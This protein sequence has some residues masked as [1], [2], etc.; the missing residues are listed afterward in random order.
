MGEQD[1]QAPAVVVTEKEV[2]DAKV[3]LA[4]RDYCVDALIPLNECRR[5]NFY[6]PWKC[7]HERHAYELCQYKEYKRRVAKHNEAEK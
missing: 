7:E 5:K 1:L 3:P 4:F 2:H 6:L